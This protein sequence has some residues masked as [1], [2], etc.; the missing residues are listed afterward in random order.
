LEN[1]TTT[2]VSTLSQR[3]GT[4]ASDDLQAVVTGHSVTAIRAWVSQTLW[5]IDREHTE[6]QL[7]MIRV[8]TLGTDQQVVIFGLD[9]LFAQLLELIPLPT[10]VALGNRPFAGCKSVS[11]LD[12]VPNE[13]LTRHKP[14]RSFFVIFV[15][16]E[17]P[18]LIVLLL[19][20]AKFGHTLGDF[21]GNVE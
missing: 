9:D 18:C 14:N 3:A 7:W 11:H 4:C 13:L 10:A 17:L 12:R 20:H 19:Q 8:P 6:L 16:R 1:P 5:V 15:G 2:F 21:V